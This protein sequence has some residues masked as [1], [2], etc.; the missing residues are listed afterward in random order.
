MIFC[1]SSGIPSFSKVAR[2]SGSTSS[3]LA[4]VFFGFGA[5]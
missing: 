3:M 2:I 5:A 4:S 1:S